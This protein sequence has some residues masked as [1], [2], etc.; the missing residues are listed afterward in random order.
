MRIVFAGTP[1]LAQRQLAALLETEH[2]VVAVYTQPDRR[3][4]RGLQVTPSP[5]KALALQHGIPVEQPTTLKSQSTVE[6]L[7]HYEADLMLVVAYGLLLP[8][9][10]LTTP[11]LGCMN[12]HLSLLPKWRG[13]APIQYTLLSGDTQTGVT[14]MQMDAGLDTGDILA[15]A[16][17][18]IQ[19]TDTSESLLETLGT[20]GQ[21]MIKND[22]SQ[23]LQNPKPIPQNNNLSTHAPKIQKQDAKISFDENYMSIDRKIRA[24]TPWPI[25]FFEYNGENIKIIKASPVSQSHTNKPGTILEA[26]KQGILV[27]CNDGA[28]LLTDLQFPGKKRAHVKDILNAKRKA[29]QIGLCL[30]ESK[31]EQKP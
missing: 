17:Y 13:A 7:K 15:Q 1:M 20:M 29:F 9:D 24:Y 30:G 4:G 27:A 28:L 31:R 25:A 5:V 22:L 2:D 26:D 10:V 8:P 6:Q 3:Q 16:E 14:L 23:I 21:I 18:T 19:N 12:M 11:R